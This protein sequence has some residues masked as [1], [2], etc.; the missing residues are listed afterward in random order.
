MIVISWDVG[1]INLAYCIINYTDNEFKILDWNIIDLMDEVN[2]DITCEGKMKNG[3]PC[4]SKAS[5][6][7][8]CDG[9]LHGFCRTHQSASAP[10]IESQ[11]LRINNSF[12]E[13]VGLE[14][15]MQCEHEGK[16]AS[17]CTAKVTHMHINVIAGQPVLPT[18]VT[19]YCKAHYKQKLALKLK[20]IQLLPIKNLSAK[21]YP[22]A[23]IQLTLIKRL[24][25]LL[26]MFLSH[27][28]EQVLVENQPAFKNP[29]MK[30]IS[31]TLFDYF[32]IRCIVDRPLNNKINLVRFLS[33]SNK[34]KVNKDN[35][36]EV[37]KYKLTKKL[38]ITYT[39]QLLAT[40]E[41]WLNFM[42]RKSKKDDLCDSFLQGL[43]YLTTHSK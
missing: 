9:K 38:A 36:I 37:T 40:H 16:S 24:D 26:P 11:T 18:Q 22:V 27:S 14:S 23:K 39:V 31:S 34:L 33:P 29:K 6:C 32:M 8:S 17:Q 13:V 5:Q 7:V 42:Q 20:E 15:G 41:H 25:Q 19:V 30:S 21:I 12:H 28:I 2:V 4:E 10:L 43:Y 35:T 3:K 1:V